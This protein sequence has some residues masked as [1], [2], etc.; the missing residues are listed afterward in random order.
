MVAAQRYEGG[1]SRLSYGLLG[2]VAAAPKGF[3]LDTVLVVSSGLKRAVL[4]WGSVL[5]R[6]YAKQRGAAWR[7]DLSLT[8]LGYGTQ[9]GAYYYYNNRDST[10]EQLLLHVHASC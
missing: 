8:T 10:Y 4:E 5:L 9:N 2:S 6:R 3:G 1:R 7:R